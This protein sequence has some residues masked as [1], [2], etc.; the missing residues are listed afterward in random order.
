MTLIL[1]RLA[2]C[3]MIFADDGG[4]QYF[5]FEHS[6]WNGL[7]VA[8]LAF[9]WFID[10]NGHLENKDLYSNNNL[11]Y[12]FL[13][14]MGTCI[15]I[16]IQSQKRR[17]M[18]NMK[19]LKRIFIRSLKLILLGIIVNTS[20]KCDPVQL[21]TLRLPGVLQRFGICYFIT[22]LLHL[23]FSECVSRESENVN[24][25]FSRN[26]WKSVPRIVLLFCIVLHTTIIFCLPVPGCPT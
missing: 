1:F 19:I 20:S 5:F 24:Y 9:P 17:E 21:S 4:G 18:S 10:N 8:D 25:S 12:R 23:Y 22:S 15:P 11:I 16:S 2:I 13:W 3:I 26:L 14:I 7:Y 6:T